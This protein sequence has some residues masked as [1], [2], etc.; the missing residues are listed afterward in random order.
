[1]IK[2]KILDI[3]KSEDKDIKKIV[4]NKTTLEIV[5]LIFKSNIEKKTLYADKFLELNKIKASRSKKI[6]IIQDLEKSKIVERNLD[7]NDKRKKTIKIRDEIK[8]KL[9]KYLD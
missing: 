9:N 3:F 6:T 1:V 8:N 2:L 4:S 5:L 7:E